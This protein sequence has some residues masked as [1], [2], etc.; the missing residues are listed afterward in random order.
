M[1]NDNDQL[2]GRG[3]NI[4]QEN[5]NNKMMESKFSERRGVY[6]FPILMDI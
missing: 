4:L 5:S 1:T 2:S 3:E 6:F